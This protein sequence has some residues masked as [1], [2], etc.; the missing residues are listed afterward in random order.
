M[1][2]RE[3][4]RAVTDAAGRRGPSALEIAQGI[5]EPLLRV[6]PIISKMARLGE[7]VPQGDRAN[8]TYASGH[9]PVLAPG[10][11]GHNQRRGCYGFMY[12]KRLQ[13]ADPAEWNRRTQGGRL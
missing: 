6:A 3:R 12:L 9:R 2:L 8:R 13:R 4:I 11:G 5:R 7:L 1:T 10:T